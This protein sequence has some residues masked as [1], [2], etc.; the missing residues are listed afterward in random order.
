[1]HNAG[2]GAGG[3]SPGWPGCA[4][5]GGWWGAADR[6]RKTARW[7]WRLRRRQ[8][9]VPKVRRRAQR[10]ARLPGLFQP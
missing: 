10:T 2:S 1:V 6:W 3:C 9:S 7:A 4:A 5:A 8:W